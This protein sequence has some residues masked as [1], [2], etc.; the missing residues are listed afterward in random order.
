MAVYAYARRG[1]EGEL[2]TIEVDI[3][4]GLPGVDIVGLPDGAVRESKDRLR[5]AIR[6]SGYRFPEDRLLI[7]LAPASLKKEGSAFDLPIALAIL[8]A[9]GQAHDAGL[10]PS[11]LIGELELS[12]RIR[13]VEG[14][15]AAVAQGLRAGIDRFIVPKAN[16]SEAR[17]MG[18]GLVYGMDDLCQACHAMAL[19][20]ESQG[21]ASPLSGTASAVPRALSAGDGGGLGHGQQDLA[22]EAEEGEAW[23]LRA[24]RGFFSLSWPPRIRRGL[25]IAAAGRHNS[26]LAGP[27]GMGKTMACQSFA[28]LL[29]P[30][31]SEE[32]V[33]LTRIHSL[34]GLLGEG[35]GLITQAPFR[36][37]HH[38]ASLEGLVGGGR[39]IR[40]GEI[41][42]AHHGV[43]FLDEALEFSRDKLQA[44]REPMEARRVS[45][46][47]AGSR[48]YFPADFQLLLALNLCPCG[49]LGRQGMSCTCSLE[50][51]ARYWRRL[52]AALLDRI[53]IRIYLVSGQGVDDNDP[54][55]RAADFLALA[56][57]VA[58]QSRR[59]S[60]TRQKRNSSMDPGEIE[61]F[62][63][64][65]GEA[66]EFF[67][68]TCRRKALSLRASAAVLKVSRTIADLSGSESIGTDALSEACAFRLIGEDG[69][70]PWTMEC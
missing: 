49:N 50:E 41:S 22:K 37:P 48:A 67:L 2:V 52:G 44:L 31:G 27:P 18:R 54:G 16:L 38:S 32:A 5:V 10:G 7:N 63:R 45:I 53:D 64:L 3:R 66:R 28:S 9:S 40:P 60:P 20:Q 51:I 26:M 1:F 39:Y 62:C 4:R 24:M 68:E 58:T 19:G 15:L 46:A 47:R 17:A 57:A 23:R 36:S 59:F 34:A 13:G 56:R 70:P 55:A 25:L 69:L 61:R 30:L 42:L 11:L 12:G 65:D 8:L 33:E 35:C 14:V 21:P 29:A 6:N 43:L